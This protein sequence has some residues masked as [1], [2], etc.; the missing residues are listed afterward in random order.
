VFWAA[1]VLALLATGCSKDAPKAPQEAASAEPAT[2]SS[3][4]LAESGPELAGPVTPDGRVPA[5]DKIAADDDKPKDYWASIR[6]NYAN[7]EEVREYVKTYY[8]D[9]NINE[10]R[11]FAEASN[12]ALLEMDPPREILP[13]SFFK[14]R[15]GHEDEEGRLDGKSYSISKGDAYVIHLIPKA[16]KTKEKPKKRLSD[17]EIRA[18]R[19]KSEARRRHLEEAWA[20]VE[21]GEPQFRGVLKHIETQLEKGKAKGPKNGRAPGDPIM[22]PFYVSGAQGYMYSLDPH[23][24]LV[25]AQAWEE[26]TRKTTDS[27]FEGIGAILT[28]RDDRT[29]VESP[30]VGRPAHKA[31]VRAGDVIIKVDGK[32]IEG[33]PLHKVVKRIRGKKGTVVKLTVRREGDPDDHIFP[34][35]RAHIEIV[36]VTGRLLEPHH[37]GIA[38]IKVNGFV[39]A[40]AA[41]IKEKFS[42]LSDMHAKKHDG[43][44]LR[45]LI[46]DLRNNSG[47]LLQQGVKVA[48]LFVPQGTIVEVK[49]RIRRDEVYTAHRAGSWDI[50]LI[51]LVND[52]SASASE[53]VASA[54][55]DNGRGL[56]LGD[57]TFGKASVQTL[58]S[59]ILRKDYYIKLTIARYFSPSGRTI[60]VVGVNPD[61]DVPPDVG[62]KMPLGFREENLSRHLK[63]IN[64][65]YKSPNHDISTRVAECTEVRGIAEKIHANDPRPQIKF[66]FQLMKAADHMECYVDL[67]AREKAASR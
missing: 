60:Q 15:K 57:R 52:G 2:Q 8:I 5:G 20:K 35:T 54:I 48:D 3:A 25:S 38:Y 49:N 13:A 55:Q 1:A 37:A 36:N 30:I 61:F 32:D 17:D 63:P 50:P 21:F 40:T 47:G 56:L 64:A 19:A 31:G 7:F 43:E 26:S 58:F 51:T 45:G 59:P 42:E 41:K 44:R 9:A 28:Q 67:L 23:S 14:A 24:S 22:K 4:R 29:I 46:F 33:I 62:A 6:F 16:D 18:L 53:I 12:F 10:S 11:A 27:S 34:I 65:R 39:P 66:D